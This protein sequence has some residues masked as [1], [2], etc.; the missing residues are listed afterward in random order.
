MS[1]RGS[2]ARQTRSLLGRGLRDESGG[3]L[4]ELAIVVFIFLA[5]FFALIDFGRLGYNWVMAE[6]AM[7]RA[8][9]M[10]AV[11][12]PMCGS[13]STSINLRAEGVTDRL[14][15]PCRKDGG[16]CALP[17]NPPCT[18][19]DGLD[20]AGPDTASEIWSRIQ[21]LLPSNATPAN[22]VIT[23][24]SDPYLGFLGGPYVPVVTA[25]LADLEFEFIHPLGEL[26]G[27]AALGGVD[28]PPMSV[29]LPGED[30][31]R[32]NP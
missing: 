17:D 18:I 10:A 28:M 9:R 19:A 1:A 24:S 2:I 20:S 4:V 15:T 30:L 6:K 21:G 31:A 26:L 11:R 14:G 25:E 23:Y 3:M 16:I 32:G 27:G 8:A 22:V 5:V 12:P 13:L 7:Q 29:S